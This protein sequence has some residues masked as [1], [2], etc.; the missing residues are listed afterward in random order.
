MRF[1]YLVFIGRFQPLHRGHLSILSRALE[2]SH[3]VIVLIGS[4]N[5]PRN[6]RNPW[7]AAERTVMLQS[8]LGNQS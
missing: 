1:D 6:V 7:T 3:N 5:Q 8:T 2:E 4:A